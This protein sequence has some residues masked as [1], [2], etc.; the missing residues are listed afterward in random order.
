M[1]GAAKHTIP[2]SAKHA[3]AVKKAVES[4]AYPSSDAVVREALNMWQQTQLI[5][6][7]VLRQLWKEGLESGPSKPWNKDEFL[8]WAHRRKAKERRGRT[9][10]R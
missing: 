4:G 9:A 10:K 2:I 8:A 1:P 3:A 5:D 6:D 7:D